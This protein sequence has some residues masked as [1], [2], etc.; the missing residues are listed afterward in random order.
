M[1]Q[2]SVWALHEAPSNTSISRPRGKGNL[3]MPKHIFLSTTLGMGSVQ[4]SASA[5]PLAGIPQAQAG[6]QYHMYSKHET[7]SRPPAREYFLL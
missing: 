3:A 5:C 7:G 6:S 1:K 4:P 2:L